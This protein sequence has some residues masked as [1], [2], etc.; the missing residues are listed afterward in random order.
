MKKRPLNRKNG[1]GLAKDAGARKTMVED[2][3][4]LVVVSKKLVV[5]VPQKMVTVIMGTTMM[6]TGKLQEGHAS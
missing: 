5:M 3:R 6:L 4:Y 2:N 1:R